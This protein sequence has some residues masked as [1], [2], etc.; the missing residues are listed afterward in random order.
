MD[1][2]SDLPL[3]NDLKLIVIDYLGENKHQ[4]NYKQCIM[5]YYNFNDDVYNWNW[6]Y[7]NYSKYIYNNNLR[8]AKLP[9]NYYHQQLYNSK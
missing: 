2:I 7:G 4:L 6:R 1:L 3:L 5:E 9:L 8:V